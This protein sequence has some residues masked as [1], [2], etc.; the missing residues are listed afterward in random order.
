MT[1]THRRATPG[2]GTAFSRGR[3]TLAARRRSRGF[4]RVELLVALA[5]AATVAF[6]AF[7]AS[8]GS[9]ADGHGGARANAQLALAELASLQAQYF[10]NHKR[11]TDDLDAV[12]F[13]SQRAA[14]SG[15]HYALQMELPDEACPAGFCYVLSAVPQGRQ[16]D[17]A[18]GTL[19]LTSDGDKLPAGCW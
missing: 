19:S 3:T 18:C 10:L 17:D 12:G 2:A 16:A 1:S 6:P 4:K 8:F 11:Y 13:G 14:T 9:S 5:I 15:G 7:S